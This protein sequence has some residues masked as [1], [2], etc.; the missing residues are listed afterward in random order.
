MG[1]VRLKYLLHFL[2]WPIILMRLGMEMKYSEKNFIFLC[3]KK[4]RRGPEG[5]KWLQYKLS[6]WLFFPGNV[7]Y[8]WV[9][10][11]T[12]ERMQEGP[13]D[14]WKAKGVRLKF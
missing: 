3:N 2:Y 10:T 1:G 12:R 11:G 8:H 4:V 6:K 5:E 7:Q 14:R 9:P 13:L